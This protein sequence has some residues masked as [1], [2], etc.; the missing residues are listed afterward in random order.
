MAKCPIC[1]G[2][3]VLESNVPIYRGSVIIQIRK[4]VECANGHRT[5]VKEKKGG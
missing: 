3:I 1:K 5:E 2:F 4:W